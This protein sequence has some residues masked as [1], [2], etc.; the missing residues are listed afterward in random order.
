MRHFATLLAV[1]VAAPVVAQPVVSVP[2]IPGALNEI[3]NAETVIAGTIFELQRGQTYLTTEQLNPVV[4]VTF[5]ATGE[6]DCVTTFQGIGNGEFSGCALIRT[7]DPAGG[8]GDTFRAFDVRNNGTIAITL[9]DIALTNRTP[10]GVAEN[11]QIRLR[12]DGSSL[13]AIDVVFFD[14]TEDVIRLDGPN[15]T[16][17]L[18]TVLGASIGSFDGDGNP[19][20]S[21]GN[22]IDTRDSNV[23]EI[24]IT[25]STFYSINNAFIRGGR[26]NIGSLELRNNTYHHLR[27]FFFQESG[28]DGTDPAD[29]SIIE[30]S[31]IENLMVINA[32]FEGGEE[33]EGE[34][35]TLEVFEADSLEA[36]GSHLVRNLNVFVDPADIEGP[37]PVVFLSDAF[38]GIADEA[39]FLNESPATLGFADPQPAPFDFAG[40]PYDYSYTGGA[41]LTGGTDGQPIGALVWFGLMVDAEDEAPL[42]RAFALEAAYPNP[43]AER[44]TLRYRLDE[45]AEVRL[46]VYDLLGRSVAL[47]AD[48]FQ[49]AGSYDATLD[50][51]G[52]SSGTY[53]VRLNAGGQTQTQRLTVVR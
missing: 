48:R 52:L 47:L 12:E 28:G 5:R 46:E 41:S 25:N 39:D 10:L 36:G 9:E 7:S 51:A 23:S 32:G 19:V 43:F 42:A 3:A 50:A 4:D 17:I 44:A 45:A 40:Q 24:K 34:L 27:R 6:G 26:A 30:N 35:E 2:A 29:R 21:E 20:G 1:L 31:L 22:F 13:T 18:D 38:E 15:T 16:V 49:A 14:E 11:R 8:G 53:V 33:D 37:G